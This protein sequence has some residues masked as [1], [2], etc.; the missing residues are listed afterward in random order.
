VFWWCLESPHLPTPRKPTTIA[1]QGH[2]AVAATIPRL[3]VKRAI[4]MQ[5]R[6]RYRSRTF[7]PESCIP[8]SCRHVISLYR[9]GKPPPE[10]M[11]KA[12]GLSVLRHHFVARQS[13]TIAGSAAL[14]GN[15]P[16]P[17]G[18]SRPEIRI[19]PVRCW[20]PF[21]FAPRGTNSI[22]H[23]RR[24]AG[25]AFL[26]LDRREKPTATT[27]RN[28]RD[29][30]RPFEQP[31]R[32]LRNRHGQERRTTCILLH[33]VFVPGYYTISH[34]RGLNHPEPC[35]SCDMMP[36]HGFC[37]VGPNPRSRLQVRKCLYQP[38]R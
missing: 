18:P 30:C 22:S 26:P 5:D 3:L 28:H 8:F 4:L 37:P 31:C 12:P 27:S 7:W 38:D 35:A 19:A 29:G 23:G 21:R 13:T 24:H 33:P 1:A 6:A 32:P 34:I 15:P 10:A 11:S 36:E 25:A 2:A 17:F 16:V 14:S 9:E 20:F